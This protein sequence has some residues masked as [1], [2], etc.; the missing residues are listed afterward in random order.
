MKKKE[1]FNIVLVGYGNI[2]KLHFNTLTNLEDAQIVA[3]VDPFLKNEDS[4]VDFFTSVESCN[5]VY[6]NAN[7]YVLATPN[8][9]HYQQA[10]ECLHLKKN[11]LVE[12]PITLHKK[13]LEHL[14]KV[15]EDNNVK[16]YT[17]M[18]LRYSPVVSYVKELID[19][20][21]L[22]NIFM[23]SVECFWNRNNDYY[24]SRNWSGSREQ[25]G[26]VLFTQFSHFVDILHHFFGK[27]KVEN[28]LSHNFTHQE[29]TE[30]P[31]SGIIQFSCGNT[32][33]NM[34][35][36]VSVFEKNFD[37]SI[38]IIGEEGTIKIG[39]QYMNQLLYHNVKNLEK[40]TIEC[41]TNRFHGDLYQDI[42]YALN[43]QTETF[44]EAKNAI[45]M[46][47]FIENSGL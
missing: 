30:F 37:S 16:L 22:G 35:F 47:G 43:H 38:T 17:S 24:K 10:L 28:S 27:L 42:I 9:M 29:S 20:N 23:I 31:D 13:E 21:C 15:A 34:S 14:V 2:G 39:G 18:Q 4:P 3:I 11:V 5:K 32:I 26:G 44:S 6:P 46:I 8:G 25:D 7:L 41:P 19:K 33:G 1:I 12:K 45:E 36:T 40:P